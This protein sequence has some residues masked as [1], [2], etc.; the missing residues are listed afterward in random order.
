MAM[1]SGR[2]G[3]SRWRKFL[4]QMVDA[5]GLMEGGDEGGGK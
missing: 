2:G 5:S 4:R 3:E 1:G